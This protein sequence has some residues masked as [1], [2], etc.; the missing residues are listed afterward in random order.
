MVASAA[1]G[2]VVRWSTVGSGATEPSG[3]RAPVGYIAYTR[4]Q[5]RRWLGRL[6]AHDRGVVSA[7]DLGRSAPI[8]VFLDGLPCGSD[9]RTTSVT[10]AGA[11]VTVRLSYKRPPVGVATCVRIS[12]PYVVLAAVRSS[13]GSLTPTNVSVLVSAR[14]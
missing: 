9:L 14:A 13:L 1:A 5:E 7:L 6:T 2:S 11:T 10:R 3:A 4:V 12:T 8:A